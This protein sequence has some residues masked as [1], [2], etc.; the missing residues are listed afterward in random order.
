MFYLCFSPVE[1]V[2]EAKKILSDDKPDKEMQKHA[3]ES[4]LL[5]VTYP[6]ITPIDDYAPS[7]Y[8]IEMP[9]R[10]FWE[11]FFVRQDCTRKPGSIYDSGRPSQPAFQDMNFAALRAAPHDGAPRA[12]IYQNADREDPMNPCELLMAYEEQGTLSLLLF[13]ELTGVFLDLLTD[14]SFALLPPRSS[15]TGRLRF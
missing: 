7:C 14:E 8:G 13:R 11:A 12:V 10:L 15:I 3:L 9:E 5:D 4:M 6:M 2:K 1:T